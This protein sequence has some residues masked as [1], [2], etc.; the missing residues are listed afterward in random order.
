MAS[1]NYCIV[2]EVAE[3]SEFAPQALINFENADFAS[4]HVSL[5]AVVPNS[6]ES[7]YDYFK[8][9]VL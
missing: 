8:A 1:Q 9:G 4:H 7:G 2:A 5:F 6:G 3:T